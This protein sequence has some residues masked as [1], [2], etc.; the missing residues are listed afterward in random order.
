[1]FA[2]SIISELSS[3]WFQGKILM[4][5]GPRQVGKTTLIESLLSTCPQ[6][7]VIRFSGDRAEDVEILSSRSFAK[8]ESKLEEYRY[9]FID[10]AQKIE[11]IGTMLKILVDTY[12]GQ[13]QIFITGS[14][15]FRILD[16]TEEALTGRKVVHYL[17]P[18]SLEEISINTGLHALDTRM[19]DIL[20]YGLYPAVH[21]T[22][23]EKNK[24]TT[25]LELASS[26]L[27]RDIIEFQDVKNATVIR[28]LL[29]ILALRIGQEI[30]LHDIGKHIWLDSRTVERYIDL[31][32]KSYILWRLPPYYTNKEKEITKMH[33]IYFYDV[34]IRNALLENFQPLDTR[35]DIGALWENL[36][37]VEKLKYNSY[38][39]ILSRMYFWRTRSGQEID[40]IEERS[41]SIFATEIKWNKS[42][43][44]A[45]ATFRAL[46]PEYTWNSL[47]RENWY[48][49]FPRKES[50]SS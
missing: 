33:K 9:I 12:K 18:L 4:L 38:H 8:V 27:Y 30:S 2:R 34:G 23:S 36:M 42:K 50:L 49:A 41:G 39:H 11:Y 25:L 20:R 31:L 43:K 35:N 32:E 16:M 1:M 37:M 28:N 13:K 7:E 6:D 48:E 45:P 21:N 24:Q 26:Y 40:L 14:S 17:Y 46:Y 15:S 3:E 47:Q 29:K 19:E 22:K 5:I 44:N 10:E